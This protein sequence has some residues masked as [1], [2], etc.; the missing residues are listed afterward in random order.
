MIEI[1]IPGWKK[2]RLEFLVLDLNGTLAVDGQLLPGVPE[3][4]G[5]LAGKLNI[6]VLTADTFG[7]AGET[8]ADLPCELTILPAGQQDRAKRDHVRRL[9]EG[10]TAAVGNGRNDR[11]MLE[12]AV[13]GMAVIQGEG[14]AAEIL[15]A[16][17]VVLT[18]INAALDLLLHPLRLTAAL[19][20]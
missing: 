15:P 6:H 9:G 7:R 4:L 16:A 12:E 10:R 18:D 14:A 17:D 19:R 3:R 1:D 11:L 5:K 20:S 8:L 2:L 13:L